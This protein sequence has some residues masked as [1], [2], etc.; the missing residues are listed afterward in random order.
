LGWTVVE[1]E[2]IVQ[3]MFEQFCAAYNFCQMLTVA[4]GMPVFCSC[5][6]NNFW[7]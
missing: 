2:F 3:L 4:R 6:F 5:F 7:M 1:A